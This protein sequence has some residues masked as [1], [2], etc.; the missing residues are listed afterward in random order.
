M[1]TGE[2]KVPPPSA[3]L[4]KKRWTTP[5]LGLRSPQTTKIVPSSATSMLDVPPVM[6]AVTATGTFWPYV[7]PP[8]RDFAKYRSSWLAVPGAARPSPQPTETA[9]FAATK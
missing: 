7:R 4:E 3:D 9:P 2:E 6:L 5:L 1:T 8:S